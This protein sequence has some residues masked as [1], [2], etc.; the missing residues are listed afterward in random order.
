MSLRLTVYSSDFLMLVSYQPAKVGFPE[1]KGRRLHEQ[2][3]NVC[4]ITVTVTRKI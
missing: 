4:V 3:D 1:L 2:F